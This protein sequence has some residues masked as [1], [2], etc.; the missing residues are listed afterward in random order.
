M[1]YVKNIELLLGMVLPISAFCL[2]KIQIYIYNSV[3]L[4]F[5]ILL[6]K[7]KY[8]PKFPLLPL[9]PLPSQTLPHH[10]SPILKES[11]ASCPLESPRPSL[12]HLG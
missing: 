4:F 3:T 9:L 12:L 7:N 8:Q 6:L 2:I 10:P 5:I 1:C 11:N